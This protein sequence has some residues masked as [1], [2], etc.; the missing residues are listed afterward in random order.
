MVVYLYTVVAGSDIGLV[1]STRDAIRFGAIQTA[2]LERGEWW[3][4]FTAMFLHASPAHIAFN[5]IALLQLGTYLE[6]WYGSRRYLALYIGCGLI[7]SAVSAWWFWTTPVAQLGASGAIMALVGAGAVSAWRLGPRGRAFRNGL[8]VWGL[9]TIVNSVLATANNAAHIGGLVSG[10]LA[11]FIFGR[12]G[13]GAIEQLARDV[14]PPDDL[15]GGITC[16][17][18]AAGNPPGA[19]FCGACGGPLQ[20][21]SVTPS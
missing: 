20:P 1:L 6:P 13:K 17:R 5:M 21:A 19:R 9:V 15:A 10:A 16:P 12:R 11:S 4:L 18:C 14:H 7:S 3:R 8:L 2:G